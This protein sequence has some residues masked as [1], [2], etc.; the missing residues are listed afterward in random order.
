MPIHELEV[1]APA[2][3]NLF[4]SVL[5]KRVDGYHDIV[6]VMQKLTLADRLHLCLEGAG[7]V[8]RCPSSNLPE[9]SRNLVWKA[10]RLF[11]D[12]TG[13]KDHVR[14]TLHKEIPVAAG[15]GGGSSDAA[16]VLL[17]LNRLCSAG[18]EQEA[19]L[20][21]ASRL[22]AD[23]P[24]FV[25]DMRA[26]LATGTGTDLQ[27][28]AGL[29]G[30]WLVLVNPGVTV[31]TRWVYENLMLTSAGNPYKLSGSFH[32]PE[33]AT[34]FLAAVFDRRGGEHS[35]FNDL[36]RV[37]IGAHPVI[38]SIKEQLINDG[39]CA[40]L[41]SGSGPTVFGVFRSCDLAEASRNRFRQQYQDVFLVTPL[42]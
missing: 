38:A 39:A 23:V 40:A 20:A 15:L 6:S 14:I 12:H 1:F 36:E 9:D 24:F 26:A 3:V 11:F 19:L 33:G 42:T 18:V 27:P 2:K 17:G 41:M 16:S 5:G 21:M 34:T 35:L 25:T 29:Q 8:L 30:Y 13:I 37:T 10:A 7:L 28:I 22:G 32:L 31:S 4:L